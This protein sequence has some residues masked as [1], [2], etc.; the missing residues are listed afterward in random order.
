MEHFLQDMCCAECFAGAFSFNPYLQSFK[1][2][3]TIIT[4]LQR[5]GLNLC[6][7]T[8]PR[9]HSLKGQNGNLSLGLFANSLLLT[10]SLKASPRTTGSC[11]R[12]AWAPFS[13]SG[14]GSHGAGPGKG[15]AR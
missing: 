10:P 12:E 6:K 13:L 4:V 15:G 14:L 9:S 1:I 2:G 11:G 5:R 7:V 3:A 8:C